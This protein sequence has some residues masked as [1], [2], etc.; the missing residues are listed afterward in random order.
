M[1]VAEGS[2]MGAPYRR[3]A[4]GGGGGP[5]RKILKLGGLWNDFLASL[6]KAHAAAV[7]AVSNGLHPITPKTS[8]IQQICLRKI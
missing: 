8:P 4:C 1:L 6:E 2:I 7:E 3:E 5:L